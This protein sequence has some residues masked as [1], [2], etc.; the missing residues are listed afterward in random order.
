MMFRCWVDT[1]CT[2][3][4]ISRDPRNRVDGYYGIKPTRGT[5]WHKICMHNNM[6]MGETSNPV[7]FTSLHPH[8][9]SVCAP[10]Q[11][12]FQNRNGRKKNAIFDSHIRVPS[13]MWHDVFLHN[14]SRSNVIDGGLCSKTHYDVPYRDYIVC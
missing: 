9:S 2:S 11:E 8:I 1:A 6:L 14:F 4:H 3:E 10:K 13:G 12:R 7:N 5:C